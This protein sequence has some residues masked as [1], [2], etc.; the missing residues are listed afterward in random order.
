MRRTGVTR[1]SIVAAILRKDF[2]EYT[3]D[4]VWL[5]LTVVG[6]AAYVAMFY[7]LPDTVDE[8]IDL[9][10]TPPVQE[11]LDDAKRVAFI[12]GAT[13]E[14]LEEI[15][16][17]D[18]AQEEEGVALVEVDTE[19][20]LAGVVSGDLEAWRTAEGDVVVRDP[21]RGTPAPQDAERVEPVIGIAFPDGFIARTA[22]GERMTVKVYSDAAVPSELQGAMESFVR[23]IAFQAVG[24]DRPVVVPDQDEII[25]GEDRAGSQVSLREKL[26]PMLA[27]FVLMIETFSLSALIASEVAQRTVTAI[28]ITPARIGDVLASKTILGTGLAL[29]QAALLLALV[30]AY[31]PDNWT[32]LAVTVLIGAVMFTGVAMVIGAAGKDFLGTLF[33]GILFVI[34]LAIPSFTVLFPGTTAAWVRAMPTYPVIDVLVGAT[35]YGEGWAESWTSLAYAAAWLVVVYVVGLVVL[36]RKVQSL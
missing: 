23:E 26:R 2:T 11:M 8:T 19:T 31:T 15:D 32:L 9:A 17:T 25:L 33:Y 36:R 5:A 7:L 29:G 13:A 18:F 22:L 28:L 27:F 3:R 4:R 10:I 14:Q 1:T 20:E 35:I 21:S 30:G 34:P 6:I 12:F 24:A 16:D